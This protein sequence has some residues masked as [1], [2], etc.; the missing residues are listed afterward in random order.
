MTVHAPLPQTGAGFVEHD[1]RIQYFIKFDTTQNFGDYLPELFCKA[2]LLHPKVEADI[3]RLVGS[4][5]DER[6]IRRDLRK[7]VGTPDGLMAF[8]GCGKRDVTPISAE[9]LDKCLFFGV[10]GPLTRDA[11]GLPASTVL[12]DP[13]LLAP[14]LFQPEGEAGRSGR[15]ICVPHTHDTLSPAE[16]LTLSGCDSLVSP[17]VDG[18]EAGLLGILQ[19]IWDASF[20]LTGSLHAAIIAFAYGRPFA[21]WDTGHV[22]APFKWNDFA[23][24]VGLPDTFVGALAEGQALY[25]DVLE[26]ARRPLPLTPMLDVCPF[27]VRPSM[28]VKALAHDGRLDP[29]MAEATATALASLPGED[30]ATVYDL[31]S[32][33]RAHRAKR[34]GLSGQVVNALSLR[35][36]ALKAKLKG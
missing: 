1:E 35:A 2:L 31:Q 17:V 23:T 16:L 34:A 28:L 7:A 9:V 32:A 11:L 5:I 20:V 26:P 19:Q 10:R 21:F 36:Q 6:W 24:S 18:S 27:Q 3:F 30:L 15:T 25:R 22:D 13:G 12:G 4:V 33:S 14:L 29:A 8:W